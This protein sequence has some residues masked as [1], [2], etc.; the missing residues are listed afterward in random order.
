MWAEA[1]TLQEH[2]ECRLAILA[3]LRPRF[4]DALLH[5]VGE[6]LDGGAL[7]DALQR[8]KAA[9]E[10]LRAQPS[11]SSFVILQ[12]YRLLD[13]ELTNL[14]FADR[15]K[16]LRCRF[17]RFPPVPDMRNKVDALLRDWGED[18]NT[19]RFAFRLLRLHPF[20]NGNGRFARLL[21]S[22][23]RA[24]PLLFKTNDES[25]RAWHEAVSA[26]SWPE[27]LALVER[28]KREN[29]MLALRTTLLD[30]TT[31]TELDP[32]DPDP[33]NC[34]AEWVRRNLSDSDLSDYD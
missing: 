14:T 28:T 12:T 6:F 15:K 21:L 16:W 32:P 22:G 30:D 20:R 13:A 2:G 19:A 7:W 11:I 26:S 8:Y 25:A 1:F 27:L 23:R 10:Y 17:H 3:L 18:G 34:W 4:P 31:T 9:R 5:K 24:I 33:G 29:P